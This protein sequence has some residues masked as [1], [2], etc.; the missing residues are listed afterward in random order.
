M[1]SPLGSIPVG[2]IHSFELLKDDGIFGVYRKIHRD[3]SNRVS[4]VIARLP[5]IRA[6]TEPPASVLS[7]FNGESE[8]LR[9]FG[10]WKA[11]SIARKRKRSKNDAQ[12]E[13]DLGPFKTKQQVRLDA[14][15]RQ[16]RG[17]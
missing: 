10:R 15:S 9:T 2:A 4:F 14:L 17:G 13:F 11:Q 5:S 16:L 12:R 8:A 1:K 7:E 3:G 6:Y